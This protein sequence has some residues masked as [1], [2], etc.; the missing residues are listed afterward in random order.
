MLSPRSCTKSHPLAAHLAATAAA[1]WNWPSF[2]LPVS[3]IA[4][5]R[6]VPVDGNGGSFPGGGSAGGAVSTL[7]LNENS[8]VG[9]K[10]M[11]TRPAAPLKTQGRPASDSSEPAVPGVP[12]GPCGPAGPAGPVGP[13]GPCGPVAPVGPGTPAAFKVSRVSLGRHA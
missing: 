13:I 3:P 8:P 1:T 5:N 9:E 7:H 10:T 6:T 2:P 12:G 11:A 4:T